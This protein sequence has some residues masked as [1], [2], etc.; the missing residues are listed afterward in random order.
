MKPSVDRADSTEARRRRGY[1]SDIAD[2]RRVWTAPVRFSVLGTTVIT[3]AFLL[4]MALSGEQDPI[5]L[6]G[7]GA[8]LTFVAFFG[9][10]A[11][12]DGLRNLQ[13]RRDAERAGVHDVR[14]LLE[15]Q[16]LLARPPADMDRDLGWFGYAISI[17]ILWAL[18]G[19]VTLVGRPRSL[20]FD[21]SA[22]VGFG[23]LMTLLLLLQPVLEPR[24]TR[25]PAKAEY[26]IRHSQLHAEDFPRFAAALELLAIAGGE[27]PAKMQFRI[28]SGEG[29][30]ALI[31]FEAGAPALYLS[32][33]MLGSFTPNELLA[34]VTHMIARTRFLPRKRD[35]KVPSIRTSGVRYADLEALKLT[36]DPTA[37]IGAIEKARD[38]TRGR[39]VGWTIPSVLG[40]PRPYALF[41][42]D[43]T[44][45]VE[46]SGGRIERV[47]RLGAIRRHVREAPT[48]AP[49]PRPQ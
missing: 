6:L 15:R 44:N 37:L 38:G 13:N 26:G 19:A 34:V 42:E 25:R 18:L 31:R 22:V 11:I 5:P 21:V 17:V 43:D 49:E 23:V 12:R 35:H 28:W 32:R 2:Q 41:A 14:P 16:S 27:L 36:R 33:G 48:V 45:V 7:M 20:D 8:A 39:W 29:C 3:T 4:L 40:P 46:S 47:D 30:N 1:D 9:D 10:W 24:R